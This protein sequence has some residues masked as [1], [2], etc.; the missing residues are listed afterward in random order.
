MGLKGI[1][2]KMKLVESDDPVVE[3]PAPAKPTAASSGPRK[4][5]SQPPTP[6]PSMGDILHRVPSPRLDEQSLAQG[7][8][9]PDF[10]SIFKASGIK[11]PSH[12]FT[13]YKVLE[14]LSSPD[15]AA[16]DN[17]AKAAALSGFLRMNPAGPVPIADVMR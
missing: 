2:E 16:L 5:T 4:A 14:I 9:I 17:K 6:T 3:T 13:A 8:D 7:E 15:F 10:P 1:L 11:D 12:G